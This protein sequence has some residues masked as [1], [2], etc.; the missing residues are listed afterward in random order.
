MI[1]QLLGGDTTHNSHKTQIKKVTGSD[2][3]ALLR[4]NTTKNYPGKSR[5][6]KYFDVLIDLGNN[7]VRNK[8]QR[9]VQFE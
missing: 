6:M 1:L 5:S 8:P 9:V 4:K 2:L 3:L 7:L